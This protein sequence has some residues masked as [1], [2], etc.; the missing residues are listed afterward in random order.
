MTDV[1]STPYISGE[2]K[3]EELKE[4]LESIRIKEEEKK[5]EIQ[6][7]QMGLP[8]INL[9]K[10]PVS[11]E[12]L[13][14]IP[15]QDSQRLSL[16]C[17]YLSESSAKLASIELQSPEVKKFIKEEIID[18]HNL[19]AELYLISDHSFAVAHQLYAT[20][21]KIKKITK[22]VEITAEELKFFEEKI[23][24][25]QDLNKEV[26]RTT[27][28]DL[29]TLILASATK[30]RASDI[31]IEAEEK[32]V[33]IRFRIDGVLIDVAELDKSF[34]PKVIT[35]IKLISSMKINVTR[36]PQDGSFVILLPTER[37]DM[38]VSCLPT[39]YGESVV[40][41]ILRSGVAGGGLRIAD[42]G[43]NK[44]HL[45]EIKRQIERPNGLILT[46]GPTGS[47]KTTTLYAIL[48]ELNDPETKIITVEDPIEYRLKGINQ[49]QVDPSKNYTFASGLRSILRQDPD[50]ILVGEIRDQE[51]AEIAVQSSLTG[52]LVLSTLHTNDSFGAIPR[53]LSL[54]VKPF[55]LAPALNVAMGQRLV[56]KICSSCKTKTTIEETLLSKVKEALGDKL[57]KGPLEFYKGAGCEKCQG[58]GYKGR[59][60]IYELLVITPELE[61]MISAGEEVSEYKIRDTVLKQGMMTMLQ[62]GL[63]KA[64]EGVTTVDEIFRVTE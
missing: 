43:F 32:D 24:T 14:L 53:F 19:K 28:S 2:K 11:P 5:V 40:M 36:R 38:R 49:S 12:A 17:F 4:K 60:G 34:W 44:E 9:A 22:G 27:V 23:K 63:L 8:Y 21:P 26:Q 30:S 6:A 62:D 41:R 52:H 51:T 35:R 39:A 3:Q 20:L 59:I 15:Q 57:P 64:L 61:K 55:L 7:L 50:V 25:F 37:I 18:K 10:F 16:I 47:G 54:G 56:R 48:N 45:E 46:T 58:L 42:L 13:Q 29:L 1:S 31:H 33:K